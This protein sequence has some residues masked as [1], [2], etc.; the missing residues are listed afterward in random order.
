M[1]PPIEGQNVFG[2]Y[3]SSL[4]MDAI[5]VGV[6]RTYYYKYYPGDKEIIERWE[7]GNLF[8][9]KPKL[10]KLDLIP[11]TV[12]N[13]DEYLPHKVSFDIRVNK[14]DENF[15]TEKQLAD[16]STY[17]RS[18]EKP[19]K[20]T[21]VCFYLP[22]MTVDAGA[23][24]TAHFNPDLKVW[25]SYI[26]K[27]TSDASKHLD[28][29]ADKYSDGNIS[30]IFFS[31]DSKGKNSWVGNGVLELSIK[32]KGK[33]IIKRWKKEIGRQGANYEIYMGSVIHS[34]RSMDA[35]FICEDGTTYTQ[36]DISLKRLLD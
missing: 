16:I 6:G 29:L 3:V 14:V 9:P 5:A 20:R 22:G 11:Y 33:R 32:D 24:A 30:F 28:I 19:H 15:P 1:G 13:R 36:K 23:W 26:N 34:V 2:G 25:I 4:T 17:L 18:M 12:I 35:K 31:Y 21:F 7:S 27:V 10:S 8:S